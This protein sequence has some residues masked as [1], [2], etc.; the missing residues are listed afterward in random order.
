MRR[1]ELADTATEKARALPKPGSWTASLMMPSW[2]QVLEFL[3][4]WEGLRRL[5]A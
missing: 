1:R 4:E 3:T 5:A 2:N